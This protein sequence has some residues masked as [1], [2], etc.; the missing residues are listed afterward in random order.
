[1]IAISRYVHPNLQEERVS[2]PLR[3]FRKGYDAQNVKYVIKAGAE[4]KLLD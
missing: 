4:H 2:V 1:M 3:C